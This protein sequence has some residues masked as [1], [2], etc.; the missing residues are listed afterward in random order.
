MQEIKAMVPKTTAGRVQQLQFL[1]FLAFLNIFIWHAEAWNFLNYPAG[2]SANIS[3][4]FFFCLS[5]L[6]TGYSYYGR[7]IKLGLP[8]IGKYMWKKVKKVYPLYFLTM[9]IPVLHSDFPEQI[10][11]GMPDKLWGQLEQLTKN[12]L[13]VQS[14]FREGC[15]SFN[16]VGWF[17]STLLFLNLF[18]LPGIY[19]L[20]K[21]NG[22]SK[23]MYG[24]AGSLQALF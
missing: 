2:N 14:W 12:L 16:I 20:Q 17:L 18:N 13:L 3:V 8:E 10:A 7:E 9:M 1:R 11:A 4:S 21:V 15:F 19:F 22:S 5:G 23:K 6:V 24:L